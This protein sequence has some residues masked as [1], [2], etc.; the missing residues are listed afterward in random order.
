MVEV[1]SVV[2]SVV[3]G[4]SDTPEL[5]EDDEDEVPSVVV[6]SVQLV[7]EPLAIVTGGW[8]VDELS[9]KAVDVFAKDD[10]VMEP[11]E[12]PVTCEADEGVMLEA[13][14]LPPSICDV[15]VVEAV[16]MGLRL[17]EE[18][19]EEYEDIEFETVASEDTDVSGDGNGRLDE[20]P[21]VSPVDSVLLELLSVKDGALL[22]VLLEMLE[23][24]PETTEVR[25]IIVPI[26]LSGTVGVSV[27]L[28]VLPEMIE[29][30]VVTVP[31]VSPE[32]LDVGAVPVVLLEMLRVWAVPAV[33][34][35]MLEVEEG[36]GRM[37]ISV[38]VPTAVVELW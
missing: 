28:V 4:S 38:G 17:V 34:L 26:V 2:V 33:L 27:L 37:L 21:I 9:D 23:V 35:E 6:E 30:R 10:V 8:E 20:I 19:T 25:V 22:V 31:I 5:E 36:T 29:V 32:L 1:D 15:G 7:E 12:V 14:V 24:N 18:G 11:W 3:V 16:V 13:L